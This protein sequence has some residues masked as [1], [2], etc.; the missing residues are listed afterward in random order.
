VHV[1]ILQNSS[2]IAERLVKVLSNAPGISS[3]DVINQDSLLNTN[4][5]KNKPKVIVIESGLHGQ[6]ILQLVKK[7]KTE[8]DQQIIIVLAESDDKE[9]RSYCK[10]LGANFILDKYNEFGQ[11]PQIMRHLAEANDLPT[12]SPNNV[13]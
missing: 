10:S 7:I 1:A 6:E 11:L 4:C 9:Y 3:I 13:P 12:L 2:M 8:N 5:M